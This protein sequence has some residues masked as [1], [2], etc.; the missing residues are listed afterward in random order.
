MA[1]D[2][3]VSVGIFHFQHPLIFSGSLDEGCR[4]GSPLGDL[5]GGKL[6]VLSLL[7]CLGNGVVVRTLECSDKGSDFQRA[8]VSELHQQLGKGELSLSAASSELTRHC[9]QEG[10]LKILDR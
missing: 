9:L 1:E 7:E 3:P 2:S 6:Q 8:V 5:L 4:P 10:R